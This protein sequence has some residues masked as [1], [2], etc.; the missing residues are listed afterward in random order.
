MNCLRVAASRAIASTAVVRP[1]VAAAVSVRNHSTFD[2]SDYKSPFAS[3]GTKETTRIPDFSKYKGG[4]AGTN[5]L[6]GYFMVGTMGV[7]SAAGAKVT[8]QGELELDKIFLDRWTKEGR[9][10]GGDDQRW[11]NNHDPSR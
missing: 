2:S 7:L 5:K 6:F 3:A 9:G 10:V 1:A 4:N 11:E 8:I